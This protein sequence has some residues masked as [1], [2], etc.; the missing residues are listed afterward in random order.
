MSLNGFDRNSASGM[1]LSCKG[2]VKL[3]KLTLHIT[4]NQLSVVELKLFIIGF[5]KMTG[6][7]LSLAV[8]SCGKQVIFPMKSTRKAVYLVMQSCLSPLK[9]L[10]IKKIK[11]KMGKD[12]Q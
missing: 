5:L 3:C 11:M 2:C 6:V 7:I 12:Y 10:Q 8:G 4:C 1:S 9:I